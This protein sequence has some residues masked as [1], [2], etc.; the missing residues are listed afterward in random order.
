MRGSAAGSAVQE[1]VERHLVAQATGKRIGV[2]FV[3][4]IGQQPESDTVRE[5][6][7]ALLGWLQ[8]WHKARGRLFCVVSSDL[9]YGEQS[10]RPARFVVEIPAM[11][12][13]EA[14]MWFL[15]EAWWAARLSAPSLRRM[16]W[17]SIVTAFNTL[18]RLFRNVTEGLSRIAP[19]HGLLARAVFRLSSV[20]LMIG[21]IAAG[22]VLVFAA[23]PL[24]V[25]L[26]VLTQIP[27]PIGQ[28]V[29]GL[30]QF[31]LDQIG[32]FYTY[33]YDDIQSTHIRRSVALTVDYLVRTKNCERVAV[34]AH[35]QGTVIAYDALASES[36][37][38]FRDVTTLVTFGSALNNAWDPHIRP[39]V[40]CRLNASLPPNIRWLNFWAAYDAVV[41]G[42]VV[43]PPL[44]VMPPTEPPTT[45]T[46]RPPDEDVPV[47]NL[48]NVILDHGGYFTNREEFLSRLAQEIESPGVPSMSRFWPR[49]PNATE[50]WIRR[51]LD[52]VLTLVGWRLTAM[53]AFAAVM[54]LRL[55]AHRLR[56]DG[57]FV[58]GQVATLPI[59][60]GVVTF[61][62]GALRGLADYEP[63]GAVIVAA[64]LWAFLFTVWY[65]LVTWPA[66]V[67]W[68]DREGE[69]SAGGAAPPPSQR[70]QIFVRSAI[71]IPLILLAA[72]VIAQWPALSG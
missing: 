21:Y 5:F 64:A 8:E 46:I 38:Q 69:R 7:G 49:Q 1:N 12:G 37:E 63:L 55:P 18:S 42:P 36:V 25:T 9:S 19:G 61:A 17:W 62:A 65:L 50:Q 6:G 35:S 72:V 24:I 15:A 20:F 57:E 22:V 59:V 14:Q 33:L 10:A 23:L 31:L 11:P 60:G 29:L 51:R 26:Y 39:K 34:V 43:P 70:A 45:Y 32:D 27:G 44:P 48:M 3:H 13:H 71:V 16:S 66:F 53:I 56:T 2:V 67:P 52:R 58:W 68:H 4:G 40:S 28:L 41:G 30:R 47:T 54:I